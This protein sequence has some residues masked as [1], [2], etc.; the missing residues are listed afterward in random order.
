MNSLALV[1][2]AGDGRE[3]DRAQETTVTGDSMA[4]MISRLYWPRQGLIATLSVKHFN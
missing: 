2:A 4:M 3:L 1:V